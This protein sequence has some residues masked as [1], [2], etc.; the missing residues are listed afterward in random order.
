M[1]LKGALEDRWGL[2]MKNRAAGEGQLRG[3]PCEQRLR[4]RHLGKFMRRCAL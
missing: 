4:D 3:R 2:V 1:A